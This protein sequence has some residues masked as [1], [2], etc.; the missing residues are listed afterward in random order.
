[1]TNGRKSYVLAQY[2]IFPSMLKNHHQCPTTLSLR[3]MPPICDRWF[4]TEGFKNSFY[5]SFKNDC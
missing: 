2:G 3:F 5:F 1:M 4:L